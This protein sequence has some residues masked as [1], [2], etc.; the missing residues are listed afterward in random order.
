MSAP[1]VLLH[2]FTGTPASWHDVIA[3][4]A[5]GR[6][7]V[8]PPLAGHRGGPDA[9]TFEAEVERLARVVD[10]VAQRTGARVVLSGYSLG[11]RLALSVAIRRAR[12]LRGLVVV[13]AHAGLEAEGDRRSRAAADDT[14][15]ATLTAGPIDAFVDHWEALPLFSSQTRLPVE[16][17]RA[18]RERRLSH[19]PKSLGRAL[20]AFSKGRMPFLG[21]DL[22]RLDVETVLVAGALDVPA[23]DT[24]THL[25]SVMP[26]A[27][28]EIVPGVGHD[29]GLERSIVVAR[30]IETVSEARASRP[31][32]G[33]TEMEETT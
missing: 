30:A 1:L 8:P 20:A 32:S 15:A 31:T 2:G 4:L 22:A 28:A 24:A 9:T 27:R 7:I 3:H 10:D 25:A 21:A 16:M 14:L 11:A 23:V 17:R 6:L 33:R 18:H 5:P 12:V 13:G 19:D 29:V 26:R